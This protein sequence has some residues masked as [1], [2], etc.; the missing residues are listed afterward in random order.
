MEELWAAGEISV[1]DIMRA[2]NARTTKQRA[3]TTFL[4]TVHRLAQKGLLGRRRQG[5]ADLYSPAVTRD[6]YLE[7]RT[8]AEVVALVDQFGEQALAH[9]ARHIEE[10]DPDRRRALRDL[11]RGE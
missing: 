2:V 1:R 3:Y 5:K 11:A 7:A 9:F 8:R 10:L 4:T 6:A